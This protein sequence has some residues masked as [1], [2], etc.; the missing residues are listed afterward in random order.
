M[1]RIISILLIFACIFS[2]AQTFQK[3]NTPTEFKVI[4]VDSLGIAAD[5]VPLSASMKHTPWIA[6]K[7]PNLYLWDTTQQKY[8]PVGSGGS[9]GV[10]S[11]GASINGSAI[12]ITGS[13]VTSSGNLTFAWSGL[14]NQYVRGNGSLASFYTDLRAIGDTAYAFKNHTHIAADI[15]DFTV[16]ARNTLHAGSGL[17]YDPSTGTFSWPGSSVGITEINGLTAA[18]QTFVIDTTASSY[19]ITSSGTQHTI[20]IPSRV[21]Q[22]FHVYVTGGGL[23]TDNDSTIRGLLVNTADTGA[24]TPELYDSLRNS[25]YYLYVTRGVN[26]DTIHSVNLKGEDSVV[27]VAYTQGDGWI[28]PAQVVRI[29]DYVYN[30][31][32]GGIFRL[33]GVTYDVQPTQI[34]I[35]SADGTDRLDDIYADTTGFPRYAK[36]DPSEPILDPA[37]QIKITTISVP[38]GGPPSFGDSVNIYLNNNEWTVSSVGATID[39]DNTTNVFEGT[40]SVN[41]TNI[42]S[43]NVVTFTK[44]SGSVDASLYLSVTGH[45]KLKAVMPGSASLRLEFMNG[46]T[47][48]STGAVNIPVDKS[49]ITTYQDFSASINSFALTS[50]LVTAWRIRYINNTTAVYAG[51]YV[52]DIYLQAGIVPTDPGASIDT[53][54]HWVNRVFA[55]ATMDSIKYQIGST[56]TSFKYSGGTKNLQQVTDVGDSTT[57]PMTVYSGSGGTQIGNSYVSVQGTGGGNIGVD[58]FDGV[59]SEQIHLSISSGITAG[60]IPAHVPFLSLTD[61]AGSG[62]GF[63]YADHTTSAPVFWRLPDSSGTIALTSDLSGFLTSVPNLQAVTDAGNTTTNTVISTNIVGFRVNTGSTLSAAMGRIGTDGGFVE[64]KDQNSAN[65]LS[66]YTNTFTGSHTQ[67]FQNKDGTIALLS[68]ITDSIAAHASIPTLQQVASAGNTSTISLFLTQLN[69]G[70]ISRRPGTG[71]PTIAQLGR[72]TLGG[73][74][75]LDRGVTGNGVWIKQQTA[76]T[77][78]DSIY[79]PNTG[80]GLDTLATLSD[81]RAGGGT[82][83]FNQVTGVDSSTT[84]N[85]SI[86]SN[87][88]VQGG[89]TNDGGLTENGDA[90]LFGTTYGTAFQSSA[91]GYS[92]LG[93]TNIP[94]TST[95][96]A[97]LYSLGTGLSTYGVL[98]LTDTANSGSNGYTNLRSYDVASGTTLYLPDENDT[99]ATRG[100]VRGF[101][102]G[103][104]SGTVTSVSRTNGFG[105]DASVANSTTTPNITIA[106]DSASS[107]LKDY[108]AQYSAPVTETYNTSDT[109]TANRIADLNAFKLQF[110][111]PGRLTIGETLPDSITKALVIN[112]PSQRNLH[113]GPYRNW[114]GDNS[115]T[116]DS[117]YFNNIQAFDSISVTNT[118]TSQQVGLFPRATLHVNREQ[119]VLTNGIKIEESGALAIDKKFILSGVDS[120]LTAPSGSDFVWTTRNRMIVENDASAHHTV[121]QSSPVS[122]WDVTPV[123]LSTLEIQTKEGANSGT[124]LGRYW[125]GYTSYLVDGTTSGQLVTDT[126]AN[127]IGFFSTGFVQSGTK[128]GNY[129]DF[130]SRSAGIGRIDSNFIFYQ[131]PTGT[132]PNGNNGA[133]TSY[134]YWSA[135]TVIDSTMKGFS[136]APGTERFTVI[137]S[138]RITGAFKLPNNIRQSLDTTNFKPAV[139]D[140]NGVLHS[141]SWQAGGGGGGS[142]ATLSDVTLTSL[143]A[144]DFLKYNGSAWINRTPANVKTDLSLNNVD[145]TS[146]ATKN[147][148][149]ATLSNKYIQKRTGTA[150]SSATPTIDATT[151]DLYTLTAQGVDITNMSTNFTLPTNDGDEIEI[152]I[153]GTASRAIT[154]S[155]KFAASTIALPTSTSGT[156][157][158]HMKFVKQGSVMVIKG[159]Y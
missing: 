92:V 45:I 17:S 96:D 129:Y 13:P 71:Q 133:N 54:N 90:F 156:N 83:N 48:V 66:L 75:Y 120:V 149:T 20:R 62:T 154:W 23:T 55:N 35:D 84:H 27:Y 142:M 64:L 32:Y 150:S 18:V 94:N 97:Q 53:A 104:G 61:N 59:N 114:D 157:T 1:K 4:K 37:S 107:A 46:S 148:A 79:L 47:V 15:T 25:K 87:L 144:N 111:N 43:G 51:F 130:V 8:V 99:L 28:V 98:Q 6:S 123:T 31:T 56:I 158:L 82:P 121:I 63:L 36:G 118:T 101:A 73:F 24:V 93:G 74:I 42:R 143:A 67:T 110:K 135:R 109:L 70:F 95:N 21:S 41:V 12:G 113:I 52:D 65:V 138:A 128:V 124:K 136:A 11:V 100:F 127:Y 58:N 38:A 89:I 30:V 33:N 102:G 29:D 49:N 139:F 147:S 80:H 112:N 5:T 117:S 119:T 69:G 22:P 106:I 86:L 50:N 91:N 103:G 76:K 60:V 122:D 2:N 145:N 132:A 3:N 72:D 152:W 39:A 19:G 85:I 77:G 34:V 159:Y 125:S 68:N 126:V 141:S 88:Y 40:K 81:V 131:L 7:G 115:R 140:A 9:L 57:N 16:A 105:I 153:T 155:T 10:T 116:D 151:T 44:P 14:S 78:Y 108:I 26:T 137:G 134:S 146:D